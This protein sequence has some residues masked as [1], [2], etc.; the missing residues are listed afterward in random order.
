M[1]EKTVSVQPEKRRSVPATGPE[2]LTGPPPDWILISP[3]SDEEYHYGVGRARLNEEGYGMIAR[4]RALADLA[5]KIVVT[6]R[7]ET[8]DYAGFRTSGKRV[9]TEQEIEETIRTSAD[10]R[11]RNPE[12][13]AHYRDKNSYHVLMRVSAISSLQR[14]L[15]GWSTGL[16]LTK[17]R[18]GDFFDHRGV[19][20]GFG[21]YLKDLVVSRCCTDGASVVSDNESPSVSGNYILHSGR[22][23]ITLRILQPNGS[24]TS[25]KTFQ[26]PSEP[27]Y[28]AMMVNRRDHSLINAVPTARWGG[29]EVYLGK[30][31]FE[32]GDEITLRFTPTVDCYVT[33]FNVVEDGTVTM[34]LP[35]RFRMD[36]FIKAGSSLEFPGI[37]E[38]QK[39]LVLRAHLPT[40]RF[41][42]RESVKVVATRSPV[43]LAS[44][45]F[46]DAVLENYRPDSQGIRSLLAALED[47][48]SR[49]IQWFEEVQYFVIKP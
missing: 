35:N 41:S 39:G 19:K 43:D 21:D 44:A 11:L 37:L 25:Q 7:R 2:I 29:G 34:L 32:E 14:E 38:R 16:M 42:T 46:S 4:E 9:V 5:A 30:A 47:L 1:D 33:V 49:G 10:A 17:F 8:T 6:V 12:L 27:D 45:D 24:I 26:I 15:K 23:S 13:V 22:I 48:D 28:L 40:D 20:T 3:A 36:T 18:V 31:V